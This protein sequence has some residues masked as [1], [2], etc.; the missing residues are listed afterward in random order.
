MKQW[1]PLTLFTLAIAALS[2]ASCA[3]RGPREVLVPT[4]Q[5]CVDRAD[6]P[7]PTPP[8]GTLPDDARSASLILAEAI[9]RLR[10]GE[11]VRDALLDGC[12]R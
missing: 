8:I 11:R 2:L 10:S 6:R 3:S 1:R 5:P 7:A 9:L 4:R 12:T